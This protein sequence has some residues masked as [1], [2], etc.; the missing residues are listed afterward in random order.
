[1]GMK[2]PG[3]LRVYSVTRLLPPTPQLLYFFG[4]WVR[5]M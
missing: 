3:I 4:T 1:M 2:T 5:H